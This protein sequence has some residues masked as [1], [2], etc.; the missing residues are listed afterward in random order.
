MPIDTDPNNPVINPR[1]TDP[2]DISPSGLW[3]LDCQGCGVPV[4][5]KPSKGAYC[6]GCLEMHH[7]ERAD[8][9]AGGRAA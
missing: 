6:A 1:P 9:E 2:R 3:L 4:W 7:R 8:F 5:T